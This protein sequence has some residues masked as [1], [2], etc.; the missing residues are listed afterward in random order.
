MSKPLIFSAD[1]IARYHLDTRHIPAIHASL[2][3]DEAESLGLDSE[4]IALACGRKRADLLTSHERITPIEIFK[5]LEAAISIIGNGDF[6]FKYGRTVDSISS[7]RTTR[8]AFSAPTIEEAINRVVHFTEKMPSVVTASSEIIDDQ[9]RVRVRAPWNEKVLPPAMH[10]FFTEAH[11][12]LCYKK[13]IDFLGR[14]PSEIVLRFAHPEPP[15]RDGFEE[16]KVE[17]IYNAGEN[18]V[19]LPIALRNAPNVQ[20]VKCLSDQAVSLCEEKLKE[21]TERQNIARTVQMSKIIYA[22]TSGPNP[23]LAQIAKQLNISPRTLTRNLKQEGTR[24]QSIIAQHK[25]TLA[26]ELLAMKN[27]TIDSIANELEFSDTSNFRRAFKK[28]ANKTPK[29]HRQSVLLG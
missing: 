3:C 19:S 26:K 25:F 27:H 7:G 21:H 18:S 8:V 29:E 2:L 6:G 4:P 16:L 11:I 9:F 28:W 13:T 5:A 20:Y 17:L 12:S 10:R 24:F 1:D 23:D 22:W 14:H 15:D